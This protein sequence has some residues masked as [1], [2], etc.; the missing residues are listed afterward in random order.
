MARIE[1]VGVLGMGFY[2]YSSA[3]PVENPGLG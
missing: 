2:D 1:T 3:E